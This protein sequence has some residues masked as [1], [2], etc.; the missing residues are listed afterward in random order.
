MLGA[1][2]LPGPF[3]MSPPRIPSLP[4]L[5]S[6]CC[7]RLFSPRHPVGQAQRT[8]CERCMRLAA[9]AE[10]SRACAALVSP[11]LLSTADSV[12]AALRAK[13][14]RAQPV[15][16]ALLALGPPARALVPDIF[17]C[18]CSGCCAAGP[19]GMRPSALVMGM[20][21]QPTSP[22]SCSCLCPHLGRGVFAPL[23]IQVPLCC[24]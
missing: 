1:S 14:P 11:P 17:L 3:P 21:S 5:S 15:R 24:C 10:L 9:E 2:V 8:G 13:H 7:P 18:G 12:L 22:W 16:P 6:S 20:R 23:S 19:T 4:G